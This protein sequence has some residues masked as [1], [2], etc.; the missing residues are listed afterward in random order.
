MPSLE[1]FLR[2][3]APETVAPEPTVRSIT[4]RC[5]HS[6]CRRAWCVPITALVPLAGRQ[7]LSWACPTCRRSLQA[8]MVE[9]IE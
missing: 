3:L 9:V 4:L 6:F 7:G 2:D 8:D 1:T 5:P